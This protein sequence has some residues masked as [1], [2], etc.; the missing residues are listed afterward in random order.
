[1][2]VVAGMGGAIVFSAAPAALP[3]RRGPHPGDCASLAHQ[4]RAAMRIASI[5]C[6]VWC[7]SRRPGPL[8]CG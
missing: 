7:H 1:M 3:A 6:I 4:V 8:Q 2:W 5:W